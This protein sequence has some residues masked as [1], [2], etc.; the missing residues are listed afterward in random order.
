L[1]RAV[2]R[3]AFAALPLAA[4]L[5]EKLRRGTAGRRDGGKK[6]RSWAA[7]QRDRARPL[8]WFHAPSVGE[9]LQA[10]AILEVLRARHPDWQI[11][12]THF[13]P[14]AESSAAKQP[15]DV[16]AY[17]P[18]DLPA[19]VDAVLDALAPSALVFVKLDVWPELATRAAARGIPVLLVAATVSPV[20]GRTGWP[21]RA[22]TRPAYE[23]ITRAG[24]IAEDDA[25]RLASLGVPRER[26][27]ITGDPR[28]DSVAAMV[29]SAT[30]DA[31]IL[32]R[33]TRGTLVAGSTWGA[34]ETVLL[35]AFEL[36]RKQHPEA[37]LVIVPHEPTSAHLDAVDHAARQRGLPGPVRL[38]A[39]RG[40]EPFVLVD[41][42]GVLARLYGIG[43]IAYVGG[44]F[45]RAGLHSVLEPA[46]WGVPVIFGPN[47]RSSREAGLLLQA[48]GG[49]SLDSAKRLATAWGRWL[50]GNPDRAD[51]GAAALQVVRSGLG[52]AEANARLIEAALT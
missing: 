39:V 9:G 20:S 15:A 28:F 31:P 13:S 46:A 27:A 43:D 36:V 50:E 32:K 1:Y 52:G 44:G 7:T 19:E 35:D 2:A 25:A 18:A 37:G 26:I 8:L 5:S 40:D 51:P 45:G 33:T 41:R 22:L 11:A 30:N 38:S 17:L 34:D 21:A 29:A 6:L 49:V 14:S 16:H 4:P 10:R 42:V 23:A 48:G 24:A 3:L 47:W 12:F